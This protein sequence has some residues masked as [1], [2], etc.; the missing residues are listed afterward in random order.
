MKLA[1]TRIGHAAIVVEA[2]ET[3]PVDRDVERIVR[4][5]QIAL[6]EFLLD[7]RDFGADTDV[8]GA[9]PERELAKTSANTAREPLKPTVLEFATLLPMMSR[10]L[11]EALRP[12]SAD[13]KPMISAELRHENPLHYITL[14][15]TM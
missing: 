15:D 6:R 9:A 14:N 13:W 2:I 1:V 3:A 11:A 8:V 5:S 4:D 12:L 10:F 7:L